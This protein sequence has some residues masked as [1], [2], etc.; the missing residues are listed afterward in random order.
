MAQSSVTIPSVSRLSKNVARILGQ[1]PGKFTLDG[2]NT[3]LVGQSNPYILIDTGEGLESYIPFLEEALKDRSV[4][5]QANKQDVSD[6][7][8]THKHHDHGGGL[9]TVLALLG[10]LWKDREGAGSFVPPRIHKFPLPSQDVKLE[11]I[12]ASLQPGTYTPNGSG[13]PTHDLQDG[14]TFEITSD[15][16]PPPLLHILHTPGH[17]EDSICMY[18][19]ADRAL[20]TADTIL[21]YGTSVFE[22]LREYMISLR[23][24]IA[25]NEGKDEAEQ[26]L[27]VYPGHGPVVDDGPKVIA[28]YLRHRVEREEQLITFLKQPPPSLSLGYD[29]VWTVWTLVGTIYKEYPKELWEPAAHNVHLHLQKLKTDGQV[30]HLGGTG[31]DSEWQWIG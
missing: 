28:M 3:Y 31:K 14:Q 22:D 6:I 25:F 15:S 19:P 2:T 21:G 20:F 10:R 13:G 26:Y 17:T 4:P 18:L 30:R 7:I 27:T 8:V 11:S 9:P 12:L 24:M 1:N 16:T 29:G 23:K 5:F